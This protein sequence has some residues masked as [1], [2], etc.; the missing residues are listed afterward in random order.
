MIMF[1][2]YNFTFTIPQLKQ[3]HNGVLISSSNSISTLRGKYLILMTIQKPRLDE[4][5]FIA[6][7]LTNVR[8]MKQLILQAV[9]QH[10][11]ENR[12]SLAW[13]GRLH[14]ISSSLANI[15]L[16]QHPIPTRVKRGLL[17]ELG[18]SLFGFAS[19]EDIDRLKNLIKQ[20][21]HQN[22][23]VIHKVNEMVTFTTHLQSQISVNRDSIIHLD[24]AIGNATLSINALIN[25]QNQLQKAISR[26]Q[27]LVDM[28]N[29]LSAFEN[30]LHKYTHAM[31]HYKS[32]KAHLQI[33]KLTTNLFPMHYLQEISDHLKDGLMT[34]NPL[35]WYYSTTKVT[36]V[37]TGNR[38]LS[39]AAV[40]PLISKGE[41]IR[42][43]I[44]SWPTLR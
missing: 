31:M 40:L 11:M 5:N 3:I 19:T 20:G 22:Q 14:Q 8:L 21:F 9:Q 4:T 12:H 15:E 30:I 10:L 13:L 33:G 1:H 7:A 6:A 44:H 39:Y 29:A 26:T 24:F 16:N 2:F 18:K 23:Q 28:E 43:R 17:A 27:A 34:I 32:Q 42:Y 25:N 35:E 36:K 37:Y 41:Y 38:H